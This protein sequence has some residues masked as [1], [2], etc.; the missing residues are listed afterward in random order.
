VRLSRN[1]ILERLAGK[2]PI[3]ASLPMPPSI[4][5]REPSHRE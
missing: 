5:K 2:H 3:R 1:K 4:E